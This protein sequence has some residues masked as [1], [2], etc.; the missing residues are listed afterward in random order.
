MNDIIAF[1]A[2]LPLFLL[3][4]AWVFNQALLKKSNGLILFVAFLLRFTLAIIHTYVMPLPDSQADALMFHYQAV[5]WADEGFLAT[6]SHFTIGTFLYSWI[7]AMLYNMFG[8]YQ[9]VGQALNVWLGILIVA[10]TWQFTWE[11]TKSKRYTAIAAWLVTLYP[12]LNLYSAITMRENFVQLF[13]IIGFRYA[14]R[15]FERKKPIDMM[16]MFV[17]IFLAGLFHAGI[18]VFFAALGLIIVIKQF[19]RL[20]KQNSRLSMQ[21]LFAVVTL[22]FVGLLIL[23]SDVGRDKLGILL[24]LGYSV[25]YT[26]S[27][28]AGYLQDLHIH[29]PFDIVWQAP[30]RFIY[31]LFAPFP[32][33]I[34]ESIDVI[35]MLDGA[36]YLI[37]ALYCVWHWRV[38]KNNKR[39]LYIIVL[40]LSVVLAFAIATSNYGQAMRHRSKLLP[41]MF[42]TAAM[43]A[44]DVKQ[45]RTRIRRT[46]DGRRLFIDVGL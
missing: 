38:L 8:P 16:K 34:H 6:I 26:A 30:I 10:N 3:S 46:I 37:V 33:M 31:F 7:L 35:G 40:L 21:M 12:I 27:E 17:F 39:Q 41:I 43:T 14:Y 15:W 25:S 13:T 5:E 2:A 9:L 19:K 29:S 22:V 1:F 42:S 20:M 44:Y 4:V 24:N 36:V 32:W 23:L 11:V 18:F 28:R 45:R